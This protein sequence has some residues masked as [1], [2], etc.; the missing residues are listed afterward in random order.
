MV[1]FELAAYSDGISDKT[2]WHII[3]IIS[4]INNL[5]IVEDFF[6]FLLKQESTFHST[7]GTAMGKNDP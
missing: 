4:D 7:F 6:L 5:M 2:S 3:E 1:L